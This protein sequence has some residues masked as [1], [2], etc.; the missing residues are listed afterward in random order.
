MKAGIAPSVERLT[1]GW[2]VRGSNPG[3]GEVFCTRPDWPWGLPSLLYDGY[4]VTFPGV[5]RLGRGVNHIPSSSAK[6][7]ERVALHFYTPSRPSWP[8]LGRTLPLPFFKYLPNIQPIT[9]YLIKIQLVRKIV[10][11]RALLLS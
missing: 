11:K 10:L 3:G 4:R 1:T 6:V 9:Y 8:V 7:K 2:T 5:K